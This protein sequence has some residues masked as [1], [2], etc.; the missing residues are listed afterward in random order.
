MDVPSA[1]SGLRVALLGPIAWPTPPLGY[2]PWEQIAANLA[3]GLSARGLDVTLF[4]SGNSRTAARLCSVVPV[5]LNE[6]PALDADVY[7]AL[8]IANCFR[9]RRAFDLIHNSFDWKPLTYALTTDAPPLVTTIHGFSSPQIL[10]AYYAAAE[11]SF[12][13]SISD[14]DRDPGLDYLVTA[15]NGIDPKEFTFVER[16][17]EYL[18]FLGR[19]HPEKGAHLAIEIA[20]R[21]GV[22][23]LIAAIPQ[24]ATYFEECVA[25]HLDGDRVQYLGAVERAERDALLGGA[26]ALVH[27]TTR[28]E[29]FGLTM[30]EAMACGTPVLGARM[31]S[32]P[33]IVVDGVTGF[34]CDDVPEAVTRVPRLAALDRRACRTRVTSRFTIEHMVDAYLDAYERALELGSPPPPDGAKRASRA[35]DFW[36]RPMAFTD[37]PPKPSTLVAS[38]PSA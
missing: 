29:R 27:M 19:F 34:L 17:G 25:P 4:A 22:R 18:V 1:L 38:V 30:V 36:D 6:D 37:I 31:G 15:Y 24:D 2:G 32:I 21:A 26:L 33:E 20:K 11:R 5:G 8:H 35:H 9:R 10:A 23:L 12:Y 14:S 16:P 7:G 13:C 3:N 28:P